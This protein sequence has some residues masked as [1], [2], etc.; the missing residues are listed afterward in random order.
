MLGD[1]ASR[2]EIRYGEGYSEYITHQGGLRLRL[3]MHVAP[4]EP[5]KYFTLDIQNNTD[6]ERVLAAFGYFELLMGSF[7]E[8]TK[9]HIIFN[10]RTSCFP[11]IF[12]FIFYSN[13]FLFNFR[14]SNPFS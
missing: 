5:I 1:S 12:D 10:V 9:K 13:S 4:K 6:I 8:E 2:Y 11:Y 3:R 14:Y 7:P